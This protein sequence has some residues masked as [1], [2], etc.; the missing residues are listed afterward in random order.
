MTSTKYFVQ[1]IGPDD[2]P[3]WRMLRHCL[4]P[5]ASAD[6]HD[7]E[8]AETLSSPERYATFI[9]FSTAKAALGFAEA[10]IRHG[11]VNGCDTSSVLFLEGI[12]VAPEAR[13]RGVA[14]ALF[15]YVEQWGA[16]H[17]CEE[18]ASDTDVRNDGVQALHRALG[19]EETERVVFFR[20]RTSKAALR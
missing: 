16:L 19:F 5:Q 1:P 14:K 8:M 4:W 2:I 6:E 18:F 3:S 9:A 20:K 12:Y 17:A 7:R 15:E 11:Y 13:R 10:S